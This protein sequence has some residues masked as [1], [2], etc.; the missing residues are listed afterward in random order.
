MTGYA[1]IFAYVAAFG[2]TNYLAGT[3]A[4]RFGGKPVLVTGWLFTLPV[5]LLIIWAPSWGW[6]VFA[7]VLLGIN[8]GLSWS[9]T[10][11]M[12]I[13]LL[14]PPQRGLAVG[15]NEAAGYGAVCG[16]LAPQGA[17]PNS[18]GC[19]P[20]PCCSDSATRFSR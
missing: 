3:L 17:L 18:T 7:N 9:T 5:P 15:L 1:F 6:V 11:M 4:G 19:A 8:Q 10:V 12:K 13:D 14:G 20:R 16:D 2:V